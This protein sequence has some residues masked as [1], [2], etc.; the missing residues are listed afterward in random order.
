MINNTHKT[1]TQLIFLIE[2]LGTLTI[3]IM[4]MI[5]I[6]NSHLK[7]EP[8]DPKARYLKGLMNQIIKIHADDNEI[9]TNDSKFR[10]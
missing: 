1:N 5:I 7:K 10:Y 8:K 2:R 3:F 4:A 9:M 6:I